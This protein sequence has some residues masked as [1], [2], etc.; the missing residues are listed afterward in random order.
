MLHW[1]RVSLAAKLGAVAACDLGV[2]TAATAAVPAV[3]GASVAAVAPAGFEELADI[4]QS[5]SGALARQDFKAYVDYLDQRCTWF[6]D[7][8]KKLATG[9]EAILAQLQLEAKSSPGVL[10]EFRVGEPF[11]QIEGDRATVTFNA[12][13]VYGGDHPV[14]VKGRSS[15]VF[16][17]RDGRWLMRNVY[18]RWLPAAS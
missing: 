5:M 17:R 14:E 2:V 9:K 3:Y 18:T 12:V 7:S 6:D 8:M 16:V 1:R 13:K 10:S 11:V 4:V 15:S